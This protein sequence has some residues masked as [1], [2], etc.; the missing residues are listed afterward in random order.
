L[1]LRKHPLEEF[2]TDRGSHVTLRDAASRKAQFGHS[3][4]VSVMTTAR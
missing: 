3:Q 4:G 2:I 1:T